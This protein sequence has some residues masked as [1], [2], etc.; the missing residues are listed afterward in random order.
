[1][2]NRSLQPPFL[3]WKHQKLFIENDFFGKKCVFEEK[4]HSAENIF[5][6][7]TENCHQFHT[8]KDE[9]FENAKQSYC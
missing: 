1:M 6:H 7:L 5:P 9:C 8:T 2:R 3:K 4:S